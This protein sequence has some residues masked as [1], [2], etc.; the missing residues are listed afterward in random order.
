MSM[1]ISFKPGGVPIDVA[2][3]VFGKNRSWVRVGIVAGWLPIGFATRNGKKITDT[4]EMD[5]RLG[6]ISYYISPL[7]LYKETGYIWDGK[8]GSSNDDDE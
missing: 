2:A 8:N 6:K 3:E 1:E 4:S 7:K 5:S